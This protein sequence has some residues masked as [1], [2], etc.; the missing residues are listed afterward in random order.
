LP[1]IEAEHR[2]AAADGLRAHGLVAPAW[3]LL[4]LCVGV[5]LDGAPLQ[6]RA[7]RSGF[8]GSSLSDTR[9]AAGPRDSGHIV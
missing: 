2:H 6:E 1:H 4:A 8:S 5:A 9:P 7:S 3:E